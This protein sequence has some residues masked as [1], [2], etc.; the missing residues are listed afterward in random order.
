MLML[1]MFF[2]T[3]PPVPVGASFVAL[4]PVVVDVSLVPFF[5]PPPVRTVFTIVPV[6]IVLV[7]G[8]VNPALLPLAF[9][10]FM[11]LTADHRLSVGERYSQRCR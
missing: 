8:V 7:V 11:F 5:P 10:F 2:V 6:V 9:M 4:Q 3:V 1:F